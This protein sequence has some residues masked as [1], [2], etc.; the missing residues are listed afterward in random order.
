M[1][2]NC[3]RCFD[4]KCG[5]V[6]VYAVDCVGSERDDGN[7]YT[8]TFGSLSCCHA[9]FDTFLHP[10]DFAGKEGIYYVFVG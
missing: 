2:Q 9:W 8:V 10:V 5:D 7:V 6:N 1:V 3:R 4:P